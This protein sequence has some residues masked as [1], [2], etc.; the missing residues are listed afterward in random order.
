M[1]GLQL[2]HLSFNQEEGIDHSARSEGTDSTIRIS[3]SFC[4]NFLSI[5]ILFYCQHRAD[6]GVELLVANTEPKIGVELVVPPITYEEEKEGMVA[7]LRVGFKERQ[8]KCLSKSIT[9]ILPPS[10]RHYPKILCSELVL[11]FA[12]VIE[13]LVVAVGTNPTP[14]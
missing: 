8:H 2:H 13:P 1:S 5:F 11:S 12:P 3:F 6:T 7:N 9:I 14:D 10:K 4:L